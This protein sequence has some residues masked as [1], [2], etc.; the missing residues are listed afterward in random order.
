MYVQKVFIKEY[1]TV[2]SRFA[3]KP[4]QKEEAAAGKR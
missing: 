2:E 3:G 4:R 1:L